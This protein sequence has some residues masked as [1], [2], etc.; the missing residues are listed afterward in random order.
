MDRWVNA[1]GIS[2]AVTAL[3][4]AVLVVVKELNHGVFTWMAGLTGHHW[5]THGVLQLLLF[6]VLGLILLGRAPVNK[7]TLVALVPGGLVLGSAI[8]AGFF[9]LH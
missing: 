1:F 4:S 3:L 5:V 9:V 8:V 6:V 2:F 7:S